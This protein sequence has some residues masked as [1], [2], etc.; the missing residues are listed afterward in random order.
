MPA[1]SGRYPRTSMVG[2]IASNLDRVLIRVVD[3][4]RL[5]RADRSRAR[6]LHPHR[7]AAAFEMG[8][9]LAHRHLG[10]KADMRRHALFAAH[11]HRA[12]GGIEMDLLLAEIECGTAFADALGLHAEH[13]LVEL[14]AAVDIGDG[15]VQMVYAL[16]LH[17]QPRRFEEVR[18]LPRRGASG[19]RSGSQ[20]RFPACCP[21]T[22]PGF[23]LVVG[24][25]ISRPPT[26]GRHRTSYRFALWSARVRSTSRSTKSRRATSG[27]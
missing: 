25:A 27:H 21:S 3:V 17:V 6:T 14:Q 1:P 15:Q 9:D 22:K 4:D 24:S 26:R 12:L 10:D 18:S 5:D 16:D 23:W 2:S 11:R 20:A 13:A 7:H 19:Q 8:R